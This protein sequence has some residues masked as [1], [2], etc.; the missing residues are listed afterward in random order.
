MAAKK[1]KLP[2][3]TPPKEVLKATLFKTDG[4]IKI[5]I[6]SKTDYEKIFCCDSELFKNNIIFLDKYESKNI[7]D[8]INNILELLKPD[9]LLSEKKINLNIKALKSAEILSKGIDIQY[10]NNKGSLVLWYTDID[11]KKL[12]S[13]LTLSLLINHPYEIKNKLGID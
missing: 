6:V 12:K 8:D 7:N 13:Y 3:N 1:D 10:V 11:E 5:L 9:V 4:N 2:K